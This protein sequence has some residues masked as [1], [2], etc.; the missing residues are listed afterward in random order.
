MPLPVVLV[1]VVSLAIYLIPVWLLRRKACARIQDYLISSQGA[2]PSVI[3][4]SSIA[5]ALRIAIFGPFFAWGASGDFWP[6][7]AAS[8]SFGLGLWLIYILRR[9]MLEFLD[10]ALRHD[11]SITIAE[12]IA[13]QY[14]NDRRL[15]LLVSGLTVFALV[16]LV[17]AEA[18][19]VA[20]LFRPMLGNSSSTLVLTI[21]MLII[22]GLYTMPAGNSG[23]LRS[24]QSQLG[25]LYFGLFGSTALLLYAHVSDLR[26]VPPQGMFAMAML[27]LCCAIMLA[28]RRTRYVDTTLIE[29]NSDAA[30]EAQAGRGSLVARVFRRYEKI[31]NV[32]ISTAATFVVVIA[33]MQSFAK[34][35]AETI[36]ESAA[37]LQAGTRMSGL[38]LVALAL[39]PL[40]H[41]IVDMTNWQ[42]LAAFE[43]DAAATK[44]APTERSAAL[45][46]LFAIY[47]VES[48]LM[49]LFMCMFGAIAVMATATP[50]GADVMSTFIMQLAAQDNSLATAALSLLLVSVFAIALSTMSAAFSA[51]LCTI[52]YDMLPALW[53]ELTSGHTVGEALAR[54]R[55]TLMTG[56]GLCLLMAVILYLADA[57]FQI[58]ITSN[59]FLALL[60]AFYCAQLSFVPLVLGPLI[61]RRRAGFGT[62]SPRWA[63]AI[64][65]MSTGIGISVAAVYLATGEE[66]WLWAA[67]PACLG[68][69]LLL[70]AISRLFPGQKQPAA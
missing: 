21:G 2:P 17:C 27:A 52:R 5:Y 39:L 51:S 25:G 44:L 22:M 40:F 67:V 3:Q 32:C 6:A 34:G 43:K 33:L 54:R 1:L 66:P 69:G 48:P 36:S 26:P 64:L 62:V 23:A 41:P 12:F 46:K 29:T 53:P 38:G 61:G 55:R 59:T 9:P 20:T 47:A 14:G 35:F 19:G 10:D 8:V 42:R 70:F 50:V 56:G 11:R 15:R 24:A 7:I 16:G 45:R 60:F 13:R 68:L 65:G 30:A 58:S 4:N 63:L 57:H 18:I 31:L 28:Y 49:W 37:A